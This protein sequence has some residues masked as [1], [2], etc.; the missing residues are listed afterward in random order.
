MEIF[1][2]NVYM[3]FKGVEGLHTDGLLSTVSVKWESREMYVMH[4]LNKYVLPVK[5]F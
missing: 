5:W 2:I 4:N 1:L 3:R